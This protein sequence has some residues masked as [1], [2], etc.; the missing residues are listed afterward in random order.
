MLIAHC[1]QLIAHYFMNLVTLENVSKQYGE[2][3]LLDGVNLLI[4][5]G[6][7]IGLIG[8]NGSGK[9]TLLRLVAG[10]EPPDAGA[11]TARGRARIHYL[12]QEPEL[13][14]DLSVLETLFAG[15]SPQLRLL[16][17]YEQAS[18]RL[19]QD[20]H[21]ADWQERLATLADELERTGG[22]AAEANARAILTRLGIDSFDA[23]L[24]AL[25]GGQRKRV[26]LARVLLDPADLLILD[27]PTNHV[28]AETVAWLEQYLLATPGALLMVTHDRYFLDRVVNR[29]V[30]L[31]RRQLVS[32]SGHYSRYLELR[33]TRHERL[34]AA[35]AKRQNLLRRELE[36]LRRGAMARTTK[37][38]AR[39]QRIAELQQ[40]RADSGEEAVV[41][42]LAGRR[43]GKKVLEA[44]DLSKS[45]DGLSLFAGVDFSLV[46]GDRIGIVGP[47]G[48]GKSTLLDILAGET[49]PDNGAV[50]WGETVQLGY[51]DQLSRDLDESKRVIE[52]INDK[53][54]LVRTADGH[55][56]EAAQMLE[57][58]L[59]PRPHQQTYISSL[60]GGERRRLYLLSVLVSRPN[61]LF[62]DEP[63][64]DLDIQTLAVLEQF[65]DHFQGCLVV[66]S[67]DRYF[68]DRTVDFLATFENGSFSPRYP[69]PYETF[70]R[71]RQEQT[72]APEEE[73]PLPRPAKAPA[74][75]PEKE[76]PR[77][78]TWKEARELEALES[79][80]EALE[81]RKAALAEAINTAGG[82]YE[83][84][85]AL[86]EELRAVEAE[87]EKALGRWLVLSITD[88][89]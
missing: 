41:M 44:R 66:V 57:W 51:Y 30:E 73:T 7:R 84:L 8:P 5:E 71:L 32:Y 47:N 25:S 43:L 80:I 3:V 13:A 2:R 39:K 70:Q 9:T 63:T 74:P 26:A 40:L 21:D 19:H 61:V 87:L 58:F 27:E 1:F 35:E 52:F 82:D 11:V 65:L 10:L 42:A 36:W 85:P 28:D 55:R 86:V 4:N 50:V 75:P 45:Y 49:A 81:A 48:A 14:G 53:A 54:P 68:L 69:A 29:I 18:A 46:P 33:T 60:S 83:R 37:Q 56:V 59:F 76:R 77:K 89:G 88:D 31:D 67:H 38:K 24:A 12:S 17:D 23:P 34:A 6:D 16:R 62:L 22:W 72:A 20:P 79:S 78:L 15:D 64:N